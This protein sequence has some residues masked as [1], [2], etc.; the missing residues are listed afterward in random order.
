MRNIFLEIFLNIL[1]HKLR[2]ILAMVGIFSGTLAVMMLL[3]LGN[4][5]YSSNKETLQK[6]ADSAILGHPFMTTKPFLGIPPNRALHIKA[7]DI[8]QLKNNIPGLLQST[9]VLRS[10]E[11]IIFSYEKNK[12]SRSII[13]IAPDFQR[14]MKLKLMMG[15]R[16]INTLD[17]QQRNKV[18]IIGEKLKE[19]LFRNK[20]ALNKTIKISGIPFLVIGVFTAEHSGSLLSSF[21]FG[22]SRAYIPY[23]TY[24]HIF[25]NQDISEFMAT[26]SEAKDVP[27][28]K[29]QIRYFFASKFNFDPTD[30]KAIWMPNIQELTQFLNWFFWGIQAFLG[31]CGAS[32]LGIAGIG[33]ANIMFLIVNERTRE[34][35]LKMALGAPSS[36]I[37]TQILLETT[38]IISIG[39][40]LGMLTAYLGVSFL[41]HLS[42]PEW[43]GHPTLSAYTFFS[44]TLILMSVA[45]LAGYFPAKAAAKMNPATALL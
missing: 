33:I 17:V 19:Q 35:G 10:S 18:V 21:D 29:N 28:L 42:L 44:T 3:A 45:F 6:L 39:G 2:T 23:T 43:L 41:N 16:L 4:G 11:K 36:L 32:I 38:L 25:G 15:G 27:L 40:L 31:F 20:N 37:L 34:I 9:P 7:S 8:I 14:M 12:L 13:G 30:D 22:Y 24:I 1:R 5:F 26:P